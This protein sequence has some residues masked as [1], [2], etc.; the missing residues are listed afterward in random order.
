M[1]MDEIRAL[2]TTMMRGI[3]KKTAL[4]VQPR[5]EG[6]NPGVTIHLARDKR[7]GTLELSEAD[8]VASQTDLM[9]RNRIRTALKHARDRMWDETKYMFSTKVDHQ[10]PEGTQWFRPQSGGRGRR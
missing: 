3:D 7:S 10:K 8:L 2:L 6:D 9:Q 1:T 5:A 4:T